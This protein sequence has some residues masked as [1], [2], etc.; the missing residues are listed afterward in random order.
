V[1]EDKF[2]FCLAWVASN[3][4]LCHRGICNCRN[5]PQGWKFALIWFWWRFIS[6]LFGLRH[7]L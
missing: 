4:F 5:F 3:S 2:T 1:G 6:F 7:V